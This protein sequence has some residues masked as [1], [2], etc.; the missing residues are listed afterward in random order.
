MFTT[1]D[2]IKS[3]ISGG[4]PILALMSPAISKRSMSMHLEKRGEICQTHSNGLYNYCPDGYHCVGSAY[5]KRSASY[6]WIVGVA[7]FVVIFMIYIIFRRW[8]AR[9]AMS[10]QQPVATSTIITGQ[11]T[12]S[13]QYQSQYP[14]GGFAPPPGDPNMAYQPYYPQTGAQQPPPGPP[15]TAPYPPT[16]GSPMVY[17]PP[18][19][20]PP[21]ATYPPTGAPVPSPYPAPAGTPATAYSSP[22]YTPA[23]QPQYTA[24]APY[25][26]PHGEAASYAPPKN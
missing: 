20:Y 8:R 14:V 17:T 24:P 19:A 21:P 1:I 9:R 22:A 10:A 15:Y 3:Y 5:C 7:A 13:P 16:S 12:L 25:P 11:E 26:V 4:E 23:G 18:A 6:I 2:S